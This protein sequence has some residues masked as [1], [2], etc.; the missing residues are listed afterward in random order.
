M[1]DIFLSYASADRDRVRP[2]VN[3]LQK[4]GWTVFWDRT[5]PTGKTWRHVIGGELSQAR[6]IIVV[7]SE[8]SVESDW[9]QEE[10]EDGKRRH[11]LFPVLLDPVM[12]PFGFGN[13]QAADL[14][15][16]DGSPETTRLDG[17]LLD[18]SR[19]LG[20][21]PA[22]KAARKR[23][24]TD[25]QRVE[26]ERR[27]AE[28]DERPRL[29]QEERQ[30]AAERARRIA[31]EARQG[32]ELAEEHAKRSADDEAKHSAKE[33]ERESAGAET[34]RN[35]VLIG[36]AV[37]IA[38]LAVVFVIILTQKNMDRP[39]QPDTPS[40]PASRVVPTPAPAPSPTPVPKTSPAPSPPTPSPPI[41][42]PYDR[43][44]A[45][46]SSAVSTESRNPLDDL[47]VQN[48]IRLVLNGGDDREAKK[49]LFEAGY[50][51]GFSLNLLMSKF[52]KAGGSESEASVLIE[53]LR[54]VGIRVVRV[55]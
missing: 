39:P 46:L 30:R 21:R 40:P 43:Y 6:S 14:V 16:W 25:A 9:V 36:G 7:W 4:T 29:E 2:F 23:E 1:S 38:F 20:P 35:P 48:A 18:L 24:P 54:G 28:A 55:P 27:R 42:T 11:I 12:P 33:V 34:K 17:L 32:Q 44:D 13:I 10:A 8:K 19:V 47:R 3:A 22:L 41:I 53:M 15:G 52:K 5:I 51:Y 37:A 31:D 49:L 50:Q 45:L 26:E